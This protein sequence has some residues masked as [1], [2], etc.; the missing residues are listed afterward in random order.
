MPDPLFESV[1]MLFSSKWFWKILIGIAS[2]IIIIPA[3]GAIIG[4]I[5][6]HPQITATPTPIIY[7]TPTPTPT[8][9][10]NP[11]VWNGPGLPGSGH[12]GVTIANY[13]GIDTAI[14]DLTIYTATGGTVAYRPESDID[15][16]RYMPANINYRRDEKMYTWSNVQAEY[17][18]INGTLVTFLKAGFPW[19][20]PGTGL[21]DG[22]TGNKQWIDAGRLW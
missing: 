11:N 3:I 15:T 14:I 1:N 12:A 6:P 10:Y 22:M 21:L 18:R 20:Q 17:D 13:R 19:A 8:P 4:I 7:I 2:L 9:T 5:A 16:L